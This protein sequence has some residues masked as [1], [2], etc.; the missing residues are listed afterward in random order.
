[1]T[2]TTATPAP[3]QA[4]ERRLALTDGLGEH[5]RDATTGRGQLEQPLDEPR[6]QRRRHE[7]DLR[8]S[9]AADDRLDVAPR[10]R[11]R[12]SQQVE[13]DPPVRCER[14][15]VRV[16][17]GQPG[18]DEQRRPPA[19]RLCPDERAC[20]PG[21]Q[22]EH[23]RRRSVEHDRHLLARR[24]LE[25]LDHQLAAPRRRGPVHAAQRVAVLVLAHAVD[26]EAGRALQQQAPPAP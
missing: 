10:V 8:R 15:N 18:D 16:L 23:R 1:M 13:R 2:A 5:E 6:R 11:L 20:D 24:V 4:K 12:G 22:V 17:L 19:A 3:W 9:D 7:H 21:L 14:A 26:V 25:L